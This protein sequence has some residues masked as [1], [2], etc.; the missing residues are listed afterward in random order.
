MLIIKTLIINKHEIMKSIK[1]NILIMLL[2]IVSVNCF[3]Q[4][5][6]NKV[7]RLYKGAAPGSENWTWNE[8]EKKTGRY[9]TIYNVSVPTLTVF[10]ADKSIATGTAVIV[11]PGGAFHALAIDNEGYDVAKWLNT[12]GITAFVLK[13]RLGH[14]VTENPTQ[15]MW[16]KM[17]SK[18]FNK[19]IEPIVAMG[20]ADGKSAVAY[21]RSHAVEWN[22]KPNQI[23]IMGFSAGGTVATG[24]AFTYDAQSRP[25][26][27]A[28]IYPYVG[29]FATQTVPADAP[30]MFI[31]VASDDNEG[32]QIPSTLLYTNWVSAKKSAELH[33]YRKGHHG[34]GMRKQNIP[35]DTWIDRFYEWLINYQN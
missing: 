1:S 18:T 19:D 11:C 20:I 6:N 5:L 2:A 31:A 22:L 27:V 10:E 7:I 26:F 15:E 12:K 8:Y 32:F 21:V 13:Y 28:P 3:S 16:V 29:D 17:K 4:S 34:F 23:G 9:I 33:I 30:P 14:L 35:T 24:V 25:D